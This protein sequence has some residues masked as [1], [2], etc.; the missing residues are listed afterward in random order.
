VNSPSGSDEGGT[1]RIRTIG[2]V[3]NPVAGMGGSVG[4]KG[5]DGMVAE[6]RCLGA[7]PASGIRAV[8]TLSHLR[9][10]PLLFLTCGGEMGEEALQ[11]AGI[12]RYRIVYRPDAESSA[13]DTRRSCIAFRELGAELILFCG[14]DGTAAD[15][16]RTVGC[17]IPLLGIP[18]G[19]KMYSAVFALTP[20][21][22][23]RVLLMPP[24][25]PLRD[26]EVLDVDEEAYRNGSLATRHVGYAQV[27][28]LP[29]YVQVAKQMFEETDEERA[30]GEI[31]RFIGEIMRPGVIY[32]LGPGTTT[33]AIANHIGLDK[34]LLGVDLVRD[35]HLIVSDADERAILSAIPSGAEVRA[36]IS[37]IGAQG[38]LLGRGNQQIT[39]RVIRRIGIGGLIVVATPQKCSATPVLNIDTGD[40]ELDAAFYDHITVVTG[41]RAARRLRIGHGSGLTE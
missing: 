14:G 7:V 6:A 24:P 28:S 25:L 31:A 23:A 8:R 3:I 13:E 4:L 39:P 17:T 15:I 27:P 1:S 40:P 22:A 33:S 32:L 16:L 26:A 2:F 12:E 37:P 36:I 18:A 41:Y 38:F 20:E 35:G 29:G 5:T 10:A 9:S 21:A 19:V 30:K 11:T 34:S